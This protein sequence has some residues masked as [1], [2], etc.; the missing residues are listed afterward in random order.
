MTPDIIGRIPKEPAT[1]DEEGN[2]L[3][4]TVWLEG[5]HVNFPE[6]VPELAAFKVD[7]QPE[8][9]HRT[10][11]GGIKP[12]AYSFSDQQEWE[13]I[14]EQYSDE[15]GNPTFTSPP[16]R[17]PRSVTRRQFVQQLILEGIDDTVEQS[18]AD[19]PDSTQRKLMEAWY[20]ESQ[21][22][23]IDRPELNEMIVKLGLTEAYRDEF[24]RKAALL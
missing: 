17:P 11:Y 2:Q 14:R 16:P 13:A 8:T 4:K 5:F 7:P 12:V 15:D 10:Y 22:F 19:I 1:F 6:E 23:E 9:P 21:V 3:T 24:F 20:R 18:L